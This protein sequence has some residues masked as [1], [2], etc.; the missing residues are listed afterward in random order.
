MQPLTID[1]LK[2]IDI[3]E[4]V[5][6]VKLGD[7]GEPSFNTAVS[8]VIDQ[9][10]F[11]ASCYK[12]VALWGYLGTP[13]YEDDYGKTWVAYSYKYLD[14]IRKLKNERYNGR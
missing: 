14:E 10:A 11:R 2:N 4:C 8:A 5:I 1:G 13:Y 3:L 12:V 7:F 9:Y 6:I